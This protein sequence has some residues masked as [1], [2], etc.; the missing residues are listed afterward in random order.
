VIAGLGLI[1]TVAPVQLTIRSLI[2]PGSR[3][4][5][6]PEVRALVGVL[7]EAAL[8][9]PWSNPGL[10]VDRLHMQVRALVQ[11][12]A[13]Q[14]NDQ[15]FGEIWRLAHELAGHPVPS[16][17]AKDTRGAPAQLSEPWY[18]CAEPTEEQFAI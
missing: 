3:L 1:R 4:L 6:L 15:I 7:D 11:Q 16:V 17:P 9:F 12:G 2:P 8:V 14:P 5:E 10:K 13:T 18:C